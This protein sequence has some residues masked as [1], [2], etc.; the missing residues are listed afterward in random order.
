MVRNQ[1]KPFG[2]IAPKGCRVSRGRAGAALAALAILFFPTPALAC[3]PILPLMMLFAGPAVLTQSLLG[4][5]VAIGI[6]CAVFAV[7]ERSLSKPRAVF[8]MFVANVLT[9]FIGLFV[10]AAVAAPALLLAL[11]LMYTFTVAPAGRVRLQTVIPGAAPLG[12]HGLAGLFTLLLFATYVLFGLAAV[13]LGQGSP[14]AY[15]ILKLAYVYAALIISIGLSTL[16]EEWLIHR[17]AR[18]AGGPGTYYAPVLHANL[19]ALLVIM[20]WAAILMLPKRL[21]SPSFLA[22]RLLAALGI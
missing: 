18:G 7:L 6:K 17:L 20:G 10:A 1:R 19:A 16:W 14:V 4:L 21:A 9:T 5:L 12:R 11:P 2:R 8:L 13:Q 3:E 22:L 15:W